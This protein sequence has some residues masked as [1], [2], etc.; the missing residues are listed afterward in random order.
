MAKNYNHPSGTILKACQYCGSSQK[1]R[2]LISHE[3]TCKKRHGK[4]SDTTLVYRS[5]KLQEK[6]QSKML[7]DP[8]QLDD[9]SLTSEN[10]QKLQS[11]ILIPS[12]LL[13]SLWSS[14]ALVF[15]LTSVRNWYSYR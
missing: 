10:L 1:P 7:D 6:V 14:K 12:L 5:K 11:H 2:D 8:I 13:H 4:D 3:H 9:A 15:V